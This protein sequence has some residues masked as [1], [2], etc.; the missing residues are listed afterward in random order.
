MAAVALVL[1]CFELEH[2]DHGLA[3]LAGR[4]SDPPFDPLAGKRGMME[5]G[6]DHIIAAIDCP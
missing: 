1:L 5:L 2:I 6:W 3:A 4:G